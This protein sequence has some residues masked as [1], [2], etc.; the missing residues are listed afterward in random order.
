MDL[1]FC[2]QLLLGSA[3]GQ[4]SLRNYFGCGQLPS[5]STAELVTTGETSFSEESSFGVLTN[6]DFSVDSNY[7][8]FDDCRLVGVFCFTTGHF[9]YKWIGFLGFE[10]KKRVRGRGGGAREVICLCDGF[11]EICLGLGFGEVTGEGDG[12][13]NMEGL[14]GW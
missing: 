10:V 7:F 13:G 2:H 14:V 5:F 9:K 6:R 3:F 8:F 4:G 12:K 1:Y 11:G